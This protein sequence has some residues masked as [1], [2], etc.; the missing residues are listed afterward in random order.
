VAWIALH[1]VLSG[2]E[3]FRGFAVHCLFCAAIAWILFRP[4]AGRYFRDGV[5][6]P[7]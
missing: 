7:T 4:D 6:E 5:V 2:L 3:A 1:V